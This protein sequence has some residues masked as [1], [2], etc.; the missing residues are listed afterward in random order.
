MVGETRIVS[1]AGVLCVGASI[2]DGRQSIDR[3]ADRGETNSCADYDRFGCSFS[4]HVLYGIQMYGN[5]HNR[6]IHVS[7]PD[8][9]RYIA[10]RRI[11]LDAQAQHRVARGE[12]VTEGLVKLREDINKH[13]EHFRDSWFL[14]PFWGFYCGF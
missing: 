3:R 2:S 8:A 6:L 10:R 5:A 1:L 11:S 13:Y 9:L 12:T 7:V 14:W 4:L